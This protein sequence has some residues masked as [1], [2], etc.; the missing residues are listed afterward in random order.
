MLVEMM[1]PIVPAAI[2]VV[3]ASHI[4]LFGDCRNTR[5]Y[6]TRQT[7]SATAMPP[8]IADAKCSSGS[9]KSPL[10]LIPLAIVKT[11][12]A[13]EPTIAAVHI[14]QRGGEGLKSL[15]WFV[16]FIFSNFQFF[17]KCR[18]QKPPSIK[19]RMIRLHARLLIGSWMIRY[20][21]GRLRGR[22]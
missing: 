3:N 5:K 22:L 1:P 18:A 19:T 16:I 14:F 10:E 9:A 7:N 21:H 2:K 4:A 17:C 13:K 12:A 11:A 20:R 6:V 8:P 15:G